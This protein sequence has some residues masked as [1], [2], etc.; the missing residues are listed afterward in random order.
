MIERF[1]KR[2]IREDS[3]Q[4]RFQQSPGSVVIQKPDA[5]MFSIEHFLM[6]ELRPYPGR[7]AMVAQVVVLSTLW[8]VFAMTLRIPAVW[9][10]AYMI[11]M[12]TR[13]DSMSTAVAGYAALLGCSI[14]LLMA[15]L[16]FMF[17]ADE[18]A[19]RVPMMAVFLFAGMYFSSI[20]TSGRLVLS[21][22]SM[23]AIM[24]GAA[25]SGSDT[26]LLV[27][28]LLWMWLAYTAPVLL[29]VLT[30]LIFSDDP[31]RLFEEGIVT[32]LE[33][34]ALAIKSGPDSSD[35]ERFFILYHKGM[36]TL[37][38]LQSMAC[39]R[40][41][42]YKE[43][44]TED[45]ALISLV[46]RLMAAV[47]AMPGGL[48]HSPEAMLLMHNLAQRCFD[49]KR[50]IT[51]ESKEGNTLAWAKHVEKD[52]EDVPP[53]SV[54]I[55]AEVI[56]CLSTLML[57]A[58]QRNEAVHGSEKGDAGKRKLTAVTQSAPLF[59]PDA[60]TNPEYLH[61]SLKTTLA[62]ML[63]YLI[64]MGL[65]WNGAYTCMVSCVIVARS[66]YG[67]T[68]HRLTM[69]L[70]GVLAGAVL[71][72][73]SMVLIM[74]ELDSIIGLGLLVA[75]GSFICAWVAMGSDRISFLG[76]QMAL[77]FFLCVL[78]AHGPSTNIAVI[79]DSLWGLFLATY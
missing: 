18:P 65:D 49:I 59:L 58:S 48:D 46:D 3:A 35:Y 77:A 64:Y 42:E 54:P 9:L 12:T 36:A 34:S 76:M 29:L 45:L 33:L 74:P 41:Q 69:R 55:F 11:F 30:N 70:V 23:L 72:V 26:D 56:E 50:V 38:G 1:L 7:L 5:P 13:R 63:A 31:A 19:I 66:S 61:F 51:G 73:A 62:A 20:L 39:L 79:R 4:A 43:R 15:V 68:I 75:G 24:L 16:L 6:E 60:F 27:R 78:H 22:S 32:R 44:S 37:R 52:L 53:L 21:V 67:E 14:A 2:W 8:V 25:A 47:Q 57:A 28:N 40:Y 17:A 10:S 71:G